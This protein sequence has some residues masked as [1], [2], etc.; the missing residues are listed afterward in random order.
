[1]NLNL[2]RTVYKALRLPLG[3]RSVQTA[4]AF[5]P[6]LIYVLQ[7]CR[8]LAVTVDNSMIVACFRVG[9]RR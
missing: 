6:N 2:L 8:F 9:A 3:D 4:A 5:K 7:R 1:M